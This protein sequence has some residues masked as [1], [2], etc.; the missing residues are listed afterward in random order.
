M[1]DITSA[2]AIYTLIIPDVFPAPQQLQGFATDDAFDTDASDVVEARIG[3]DGIA[4]YGFTPFLV[5]Q[6]IHFQ[7]DSPSIAAKLYLGLVSQS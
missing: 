5:T 2:N 3:V 4:S 1:A 7:S 6:T